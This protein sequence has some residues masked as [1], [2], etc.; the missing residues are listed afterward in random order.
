MVI[1]GD[2]PAS[3]K[4][5]NNKNRACREIG[6]V[7]RE[8]A[9]SADTDEAELLELVEKLNNDPEIDGILVQLPLPRGIDER[10]IINGEL[11]KK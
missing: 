9:L 4:Y 10:K 5:V 3:R 11:W 7:S 1:V 8:Y 2:D 6:M